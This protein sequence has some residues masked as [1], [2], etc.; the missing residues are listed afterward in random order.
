MV[1]RLVHMK[2]KK[3]H[4]SSCKWVKKTCFH[5]LLTFDKTFIFCHEFSFCTHFTSK[6]SVTFR[7]QA[8]FALTHSSL[9]NCQNNKGFLLN[10]FLNF[11]LTI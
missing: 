7:V 4:L 8:G 9:A 1:T 2:V 5:S 10:K 6:A 11:N 3:C